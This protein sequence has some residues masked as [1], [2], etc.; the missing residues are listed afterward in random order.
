MERGTMRAFKIVAAVGAALFL[1]GTTSQAKVVIREKDLLP[2]IQGRVYSI[3]TGE[4][5]ENAVV[6]YTRNLNRDMPSEVTSTSSDGVFMALRLEPGDYT[7]RIEAEGYETPEEI[8]VTVIEGQ[9][10]FVMDGGIAMM[11]KRPSLLFWPLMTIAVA[12]LMFAFAAVIRSMRAER[13]S[14]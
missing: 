10:S 12:V 4:P 8:V 6:H 9:M 11:Q 2:G 1:F 14:E 13:G 3:S 7:V 5:I